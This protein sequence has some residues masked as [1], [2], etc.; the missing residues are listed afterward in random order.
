MSDDVPIA[1]TIAGTD[2]TGAAGINADLQVFRDLGCHGASAIT[3]VV[4]QNTEGIDGW[5]SL[6]P[7]A[8]ESQLES[9]AGDLSIRAVKIGMLPTGDLIRETAD[10]L[11]T[12]DEDIP[13]VLDPVMAGG[14]GHRRRL[15]KR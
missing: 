2:P 3:A 15:P 11:E 7:V 9:V 5:R 12:L 4:W 6:P 8:L 1:L 14:A 10:F 13:V